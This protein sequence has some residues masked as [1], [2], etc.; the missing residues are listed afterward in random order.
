M[1]RLETGI[2]RE[3]SSRIIIVRD[4]DDRL[5]IELWN[6]RRHLNAKS[7]KEMLEKIVK[8]WKEERGI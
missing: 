5:Y 8:L 2:K 3:G 7:W 1:S 4:V 6:L